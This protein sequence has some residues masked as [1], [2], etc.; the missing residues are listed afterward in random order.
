MHAHGFSLNGL[1]RAEAA[2]EL[3]F[4]RAAV[5][6]F[7]TANFD[8]TVAFRFVAGIEI[9]T[10]GFGIEDNLAHGVSLL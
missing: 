3:V 5:N 10:R 7:N 2:A 9:H 8:N 1:F 4:S 6:E